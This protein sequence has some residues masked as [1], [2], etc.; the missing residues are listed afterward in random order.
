MSFERPQPDWLS[1]DAERTPSD[2]VAFETLSN[3]R[4]RRVVRQLL[5][6][7]R[8]ELRP[9]SRRVAAR[10]NDKPPERVSATERPR[11]YN[12]LQ[13]FHL[14]KL[15]DLGVVRYDDARGTVEPTDAIDGLA[16]YLDGSEGC[17]RVHIAAMIEGGVAVAVVVT[18]VAANRVFPA[19]TAI[20]LGVT[21]G[22]LAVAAR[23][24][25][26]RCLVD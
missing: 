5:E 8:T 22:V 21:L 6:D 13:Q 2:Q 3:E 4:R 1:T 11:V 19:G 9:L 12:A 15:D 16:T 17:L 14:P 23:Y 20:A 26:W 7:D 10:E 24:A 25:R 18:A